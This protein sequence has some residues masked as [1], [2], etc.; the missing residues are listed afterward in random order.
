MINFTFIYILY[1]LIN[2]FAHFF[3][4]VPKNM[5]VLILVFPLF[6][7]TSSRNIT[8]GNDTFNYYYAFNT[9][10]KDFFD[11]S[12]SRFELGYIFFNKIVQ[13]IGLE[14]IHFQV[15]IS[16]LFYISFIKLLK[17]YSINIPM[18]IT[19]FI[20]MH[21]FF[22]TM[23]LSRQFMAVSILFLSFHYLVNK[24]VFKYFISVVIASFFHSTAWVFFLVYPFSKMK[25]SKK[26]L[27]LI[28]VSFMF[29]YLRF[30]SLL[31]IYFLISNKYSS[32]TESIYFETE[33]N[34][35]TYFNLLMYILIFIWIILIDIKNKELT[36][37][38]KRI[39]NTMKSIVFLS[40]FF[41]FL[42]LKAPLFGR[43]NIYF[44]IFYVIILPFIIGQIEKRKLREVMYFITLI[45]FSCYFLIVVIYRPYWTG[46]IP[47][48]FYTK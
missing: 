29:I 9:M 33:G 47:Y 26:N 38:N 35:A 10:S 34:I 4:K 23:N 19:I 31:E 16:I 41:G 8:V 5:Q 28:V 14:Y 13:F 40:V 21:L 6:I 12:T 2:L 25:F 15:L 27:V 11:F 48:E 46:V 1:L 24:K 20:S 22:Q 36:I 18:S 37:E 45:I 32:Y 39:L 7:L 3:I 17:K 44:T 42:A 43:F 30:D